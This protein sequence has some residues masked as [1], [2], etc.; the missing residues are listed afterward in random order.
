[1]VPL[2]PSHLSSFSL[3]EWFPPH[4]TFHT[5]ECLHT[6]P[7]CCSQLFK[8]NHFHVQLFH[9]ALVKLYFHLQFFGEASE[10]KLRWG[11][12]WVLLFWVLSLAFSWI[13]AL[14]IV[15]SLGFFSCCSLFSPVAQRHFLLSWVDPDSQAETSSNAQRSSAP[16]AALNIVFFPRSSSQVSWSVMPISGFTFLIA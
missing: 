13:S 1:M 11:Y 15:I 6:Q 4:I 5:P 14:C 9:F 8:I 10:Q 16:S 3:S 12:V 2:P 7:C